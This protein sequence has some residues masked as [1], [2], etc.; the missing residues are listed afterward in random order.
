MK[1]LEF[2]RNIGLMAHV[3]AGKTTATERMLYY[4]GLIHKMGNVDDGNTVT[5]TDPQ[6]STRGIT[7][8]SAAISTYWNYQRAGLAVGE[9]RLNL[10]DTPGHVDFFIEVERSLRVLD[11]AIALFDAVSGVEPQ[12]EKVW[13]QADKYGVPRLAFVNKMDRQGADFLAVVEQLD[14]RL[15]ALPLVVQLPIGQEEDFQGVI[16]LI[17]QKALI[18]DDPSGES[19]QETAVPEQLLAAC[20]QARESLLETIAELD[21]HFLAVY[22]ESPELITEQLI[23]EAIRTL[24]VAGLVTPVLCGSAF[25]NKGVQPLL[26]AVVRYLPT[27]ADGGSMEVE[28]PSS[29]ETLVLERQEDAAFSALAFKVLSDRYVGKQTLVR[30]YSGL[31]QKGTVVLNSRTNEKARVTRILEIRADSFQDLEQAS[32]GNICALVGLKDVRTGDTLC[33][34]E[35]PVL[36]ESIEIPEPVIGIAVEPKTNADQQ[37]FGQALNTLLVEDPSL[38]VEVDEQ[39]GQ[40]VLRGMGEL[41]LDVVLERMRSNFNIGVNHGKPLV[42]YRESLTQ[43]VQHHEKYDKQNG[44][45]GN[46]AEMTFTLGP[47]EA[48]AV[49]L[50][51]VDKTRGGVIPKEYMP[52]IEKGFREAM[53][54]GA[55]GGFPVQNLEVTLLDGKTHVKDTHAVDF[56]RAAFDGFRN[57]SPQAGPQLLEPIMRAEISCSEEFTGAINSDLNRRRGMVLHMD[58]QGKQK[59]I[60]AE[61][62]L[63]NT[64]GYINDLRTLARGRATVSMQLSH[65]A[66]VPNNL[67]DQILA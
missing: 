37:L 62:P 58:Q 10:I 38:S 55:L 29:E 15:G 56:E 53:K 23:V 11:G 44:G 45:S 49:G 24:T 7:I 40:T 59:V 57:A 36:L 60:H 25:K 65:Y 64:F 3:D 28:V 34:L 66:P 20:Q 52:S 27:P 46:F 41:H 12:S 16:D 31:L 63:A 54:H 22:L 6:E 42:A 32:A 39:T 19:W 18:W 33:A 17:G 43:T 9:Y 5:D 50:Q 8:S 48:N 26:D 61:V 51:V 4:T 13:R 2:V 1:A 30:V 67:V 14:Q 47:G 35:Q 21:E